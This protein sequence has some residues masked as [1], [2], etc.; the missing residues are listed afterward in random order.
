MNK[1][2]FTS[3]WC[4]GYLLPVVIS[5]ACVIAWR[6]FGLMR[7]SRRCFTITITRRAITDTFGQGGDIYFPNVDSLLQDFFADVKRALK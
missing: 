4:G 6:S 5:R 7:T 1:A 2:T 3:S